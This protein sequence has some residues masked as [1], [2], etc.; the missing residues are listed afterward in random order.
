[1][2]NPIYHSTTSIHAPQKS[3]MHGVGS[4][5]SVQAAVSATPQVQNRKRKHS[6]LSFQ[7][8]EK[9]ARTSTGNFDCSKPFVIV[10]KFDTASSNYNTITPKQKKKPIKLPAKREGMRSSRVHQS[11]TYQPP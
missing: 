7:S 9:S 6:T 4:R 1:M 5:N 2:L 3:Q 10:H 8:S 11:S